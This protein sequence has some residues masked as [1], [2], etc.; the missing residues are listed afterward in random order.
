MDH[1]HI[2]IMG[3]MGS[4]KTS[5]ASALAERLGR[6]LRDSDV[7]LEVQWQRT[8]RTIAAED[9]I[10]HLHELEAASL[11]TVEAIVGSIED[12]YHG[13]DT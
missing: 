10:A 6:P 5:V 11:R 2:V 12:A 7:D 13:A 3:L 9:G 8:G 4:G 1:R